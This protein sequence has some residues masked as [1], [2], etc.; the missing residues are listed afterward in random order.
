MLFTLSLSSAMAQNT[1]EVAITNNT[2][3]FIK[4]HVSVYLIDMTALS[5]DPVTLL[6]NE[7]TYVTVSKPVLG[8]LNAGSGNWNKEQVLI[9]LGTGYGI[10]G[11]THKQTADCIMS[12]DQLVV[13]VQNESFS[14]GGDNL[15]INLEMLDAILN[16]SDI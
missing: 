16:L 1:F 12:D 7:T 3:E 13:D 8:S 15:D 4:T 11:K 5:C 10:Y 9:V 14:V 6:P 2:N